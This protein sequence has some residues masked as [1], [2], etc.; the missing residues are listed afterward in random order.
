M[1]HQISTG[2]MSALIKKDKNRDFYFEKEIEKPRIFKN[3]KRKIIKTPDGIFNGLKEAADYY[4][5]CSESIRQRI[6]KM[7]WEGW[8]YIS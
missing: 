4:K 7:K 1:H 2:Q 5:V 6:S 3:L 8:E